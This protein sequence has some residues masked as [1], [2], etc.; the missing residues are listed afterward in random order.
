MSWDA[1][2]SY[3]SEDR[4]WAQSLSNKLRARNRS[5]FYDYDTLHAGNEWQPQLEEALGK[6]GALIVLWSS[7]L[8]SEPILSWTEMERYLFRM[9][10]LRTPRNRQRP[11]IFVLLDT[12]P[13]AL[14]ALQVVP[15]IRDGNYYAAS[16]ANADQAL[17]NV[18]EKV[19]DSVVTKV[20]DG[21]D[22]GHGMVRIKTLV[23]AARRKA[24]SP[25][26]LGNQRW[27]RLAHLLVTQRLANEQ[28]AITSVLDRRYGADPRDWCPFATSTIGDL[29]DALKLRLESPP[30]GVRLRFENIDAVFKD[31]NSLT[32]RAQQLARELALI[33][34]DPLSLYDE[35]VARRV[36]ALAPC[37][38]SPL[39]ALVVPA[40]NISDDTQL[41]ELLQGTAAAD[42]TREFF[43]PAI[44]LAKDIAS[45]GLHVRNSEELGRVL[46]LAVARNATSPTDSTIASILNF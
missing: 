25:G 33:V 44:P 22:E 17:K 40:L 46:L 24:F 32:T 5:V 29:L 23:L 11:V 8:K 4:P 30:N 38:R 36:G 6:S 3:K 34:I 9:T 43:H 19:W 26:E 14:G 39:N 37:F 13:T 45:V 21:I 41:N 20:L 12:H 2:I 27:D 15:D 31:D 18:P 1:F 42:L 16:G 35:G 28:A 10:E 7:R